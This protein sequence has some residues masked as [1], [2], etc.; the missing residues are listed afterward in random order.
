M[1]L[2]TQ[3]GRM[4]KM[5]ARELLQIVI[6]IGLLAPASMGRAA[7]MWTSKTAMPTA[8]LNFCTA[9]VDGQ[10]YVIGGGQTIHGPY[11][12]VMEVYQ[13]VEKVGCHKRFLS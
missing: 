9:V 2:L 8:R 11:L 7:G 12:S 6:S 1:D 3:T 4:V 13:P 10:I 5:N